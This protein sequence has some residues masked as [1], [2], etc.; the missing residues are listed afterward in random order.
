MQAMRMLGL[1]GGKRMGVGVI[2]GVRMTGVDLIMMTAATLGVVMM[3][4]AMSHCL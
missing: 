1:V 2:S 4:R 3:S